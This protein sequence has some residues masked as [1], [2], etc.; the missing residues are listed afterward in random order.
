MTQV[1]VKSSDV[2]KL[3]LQF[4]KE[5]NLTRSFET[6]QE[7]SKISLNILN[8]DQFVLAVMKERWDEVLSILNTLMLTEE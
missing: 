1:E 3:I 5:N 6:L 2:L 7:E 4:L 8:T